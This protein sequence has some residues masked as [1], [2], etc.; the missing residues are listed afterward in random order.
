MTSSDAYADIKALL[1]DS[2]SPKQ[3]EEVVRRIN[4]GNKEEIGLLLLDKEQLLQ[5]LEK[6]AKAKEKTK[7]QKKLPDFSQERL[8]QLADWQ[9]FYQNSFHKTHDFS[10]IIIPPKPKGNWRLLIIAKGLTINQAYNR[11]QE[12]FQCY[13]YT[14]DLDAKVTKN[15]RIPTESYAIWVQDSIE[16]D[17]EYLNQSTNQADPNMTIG[18]TLLERIIL[19]LIYF[20]E[21]Q[22]H[23]DI[24][25]I[26]FCS[27][28]RDA[29]GDVPDVKGNSGS[30]RFLVGWCD[31]DNAIPRCGLRRAVS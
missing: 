23:L 7:K 31:L 9:R 27:A 29:D 16:P 20:Q 13:K 28:S 1:P 6:P 14:D 3:K 2:L 24:K 30:T 25:G 26:T 10:H 4:E 15:T 17:K 12:L 8:R 18:I 21:T 11:C 5:E 19:E 22:K